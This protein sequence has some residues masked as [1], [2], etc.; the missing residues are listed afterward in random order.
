MILSAHQSHY[1]PWLGYFDKIAQS[2]Q[3]VVLDCVQYKKREF[4]NRNKIRTPLG[5]QWLTVPVVSKGH[6]DQRLKDVL[7]DN[8]IGWAKDH[9]HAVQTN[10]AKAPCF[11]AYSGFFEETYARPWRY[12]VDLNLHLIRFFL[13]QFGIQAPLFL[14]SEI[15]TQTQATDR[16]IELATQCKA[17]VYLSGIGGKEYLEE[18]KFRTAGMILRYQDFSHP[19]YP[20]RFMKGP[21]DFIPNLSAIDL[22]LNLGKDA[23]PFFVRREK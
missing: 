21:E 20:Q 14:E 19:V 22:L 4:Q 7:I 9:W 10:Y 15:G 13:E 3:F 6:Y 11:K 16:L 12:L 8:E 1:L 18:E 2:D 5:E 23:K 17:N